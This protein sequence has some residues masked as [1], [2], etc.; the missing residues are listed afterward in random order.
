MGE[1]FINFGRDI[2]LQFE[3]DKLKKTYPKAYH[4]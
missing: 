2:K 3:Q 4:N 1:N